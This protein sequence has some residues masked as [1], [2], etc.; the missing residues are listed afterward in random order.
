MQRPRTQTPVIAPDLVVPIVED[1]TEEAPWMV[2]GDAQFWASAHLATSLRHYARA[3]HLP[4]Y[5]AS[6]LP[7]VYRRAGERRTRQ[8]APD[9]M[10]AFVPQR[11]RDSY[12]LAAEGGF[13]AFVLEVVSSSSVARDVDA[14]R[15]LYEA[16]GAQ[17]YVL[18]AP[19]PDLLE[20]QVQ[21][22]HRG[23]SGRFEPWAPDAAGRLWSD[24]LDL[25]LVAEG[26]LLRAV[27][28]DGQP[29]LTYEE[30][31]AARVREAEMREQAEAAR[32]QEAAA[33]QRAE[34][35]LARLRAL[36]EREKHED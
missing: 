7:I 29:L 4:W 14:K 23:A 30:S 21:G 1:D 33:R 36:L 32:A 15:R 8:V 5:V 3:H 6:L 35:E 11:P 9:V 10:V 27:L 16:L 28:A 2:M 20:P 17:E 22:H 19:Q 25:W 31:E 24:V 12:D 18:F 26:S 13:P 34:E